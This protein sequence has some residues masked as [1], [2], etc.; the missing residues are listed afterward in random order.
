MIKDAVKS[1]EDMI[2]KS[3]TRVSSIESSLRSLT[4]FLPGRFQDSE[5]A[6][7]AL[8]TLLNILGVYHD[9]IV[10][11]TVS[12]LPPPVRPPSSS[13]ARYT[14][15]YVQRSSTYKT[16]ARSL[17]VIGYTELL[18]EMTVRKKLGQNKAEQTVIGIETVKALLRLLIMRTTGGRPNVNPP[19]S[20]REFD[21]SVLDLHRPH[22]VD[23]DGSGGI[24]KKLSFEPTG[25]HPRSAA[26][27]LLRRQGDHAVEGLGD[28]EPEVHREYWTGARTGYARHTI[29]SLRGTDDVQPGDPTSTMQNSQNSSRAA[30]DGK[31][32]IKEFLAKRVLTVED[33]KRPQD[34]VS[35]ARGIKAVAEVIWIL[36]PLVYVLAMRKYGRR[37][38]LP[39]LLSLALEYLAFTLRSSS[40]QKLFVNKASGPML[41]TPSE[42][43]KQ[44]TK[45][46]ARAFWWYLLRG[47]LWDSWT[48][49]RLEGLS[50][51]F[52]DKPLIGFLSTFIRDYIPLVDD[53]YFYTS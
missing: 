39:Y 16:L 45:K 32:A 44:E 23:N 14:R 6:S 41:S 42:L 11:R 50:S 27:V 30:G 33:V 24:T 5:L 40:N 43:E 10:L 48:K 38:T 2:L 19:I 34:L 22:L 53:Y 49:P 21:P 4:W 51:R 47:P 13:H 8:Y 52:D 9:S 18:I 46:R 3:T 20:E 26:D 17:T 12:V 31:Q 29:A 28:R 37:H 1:Y 15:H 35:K 7:E 25:S 36:R